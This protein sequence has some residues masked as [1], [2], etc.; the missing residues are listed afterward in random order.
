MKQDVATLKPEC[1]E[2]HEVIM[3]VSALKWAI[4]HADC[5]RAYRDDTGDN[6]KPSTNPIEA[7]IDTQ[8]GRDWEFI[9]RFTGWFNDNIWGD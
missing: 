5:V 4:G 9:K 3:W 7:M 2:D 8:T 6:W 1:V